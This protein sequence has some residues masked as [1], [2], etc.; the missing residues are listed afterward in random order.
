MHPHAPA[1]NEQK[2]RVEKRLMRTEKAETQKTQ[3]SVKRNIL[4]TLNPPCS[5]ECE[6]G[7]ADMLRHVQISQQDTFLKNADTSWSERT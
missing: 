4:Q 6:Y 2:S 5:H 7:R 1:K 3:Y